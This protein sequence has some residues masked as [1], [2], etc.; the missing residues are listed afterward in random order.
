MT[1]ETTVTRV[2]VPEDQGTRKH[3][4]GHGPS[5]PEPG[6]P[7]GIVPENHTCTK[8]IQ[9]NIFI[10]DNVQYLYSI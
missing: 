4:T 1:T 7:A 2:L 9:I 3:C 10:L 8:L 5:F 6:C